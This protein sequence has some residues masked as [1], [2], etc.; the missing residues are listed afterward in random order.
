MFRGTLRDGTEVAIKVLS[1]PKTSGFKEEVEVQYT[2]RGSVFFYRDIWFYRVFFANR[3][4]KKT[5]LFFP[6]GIFTMQKTGIKP[7]KQKVKKRAFF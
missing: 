1:S 2:L 4:K 3:R 5:G 7:V 6:T